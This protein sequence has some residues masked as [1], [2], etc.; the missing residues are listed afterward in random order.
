[1]PELNSTRRKDGNKEGKNK[2]NLII[3]Y[4]YN[5]EL[6][7]PSLRYEIYEDWFLLTILYYINI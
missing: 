5:D 7:R 4:Y 3:Q 1:M 2:R 6:Y